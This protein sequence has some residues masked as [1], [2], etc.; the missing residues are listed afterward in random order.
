MNTNRRNPH[1]TTRDNK[2]QY[3]TYVNE[4]KK[5]KNTSYT[6]K[7][8]KYHPYKKNR[9]CKPRSV[10][11]MPKSLITLKIKPKYTCDILTEV[12]EHPLNKSITKNL[13]EGDYLSRIS[14]CKVIK[15]NKDS[16][17]S[18]EN[19][20]KYSWNISSNIVEREMI[21]ISHYH[22]IHKK[23]MTELATILI[24]AGNIGLTICFEKKPQEKNIENIL[25]SNNVSNKEMSKKLLKGDIRV[26]LCRLINAEPLLGRSRVMDLEI[27]EKRLIDH[28]TIKWIVYNYNKYELK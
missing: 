20:N 16:N 28:R 26:M 18:V 10:T 3:Y 12:K 25:N 1:R 22:T 13:K 24:N 6:K 14:Y 19:E 7:K 23:T 8:L 15:K 27:N 4:N 5:K 17:F 9:S 21:P 11:I 2:I